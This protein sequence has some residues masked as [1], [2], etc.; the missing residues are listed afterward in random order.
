MELTN[1]DTASG[2]IDDEYVLPL[3]HQ[4]VTLFGSGTWVAHSGL[5]A[6]KVLGR[7]SI[8][9]HRGFHTTISLSL[10]VSVLGQ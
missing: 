4:Q 9:A 10:F 2:N 6:N 3:F 7:E 1:Q 8:L 5:Q